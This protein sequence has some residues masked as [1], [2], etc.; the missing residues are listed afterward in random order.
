MASLTGDATGCLRHASRC[1]Q[2][3]NHV[4]RRVAEQ[5]A[6][7]LSEGAGAVV[8]V[9][10]PAGV[11]RQ[12]STTDAGGELEPPVAATAWYHASGAV[13][14]RALPELIGRAAIHED[15]HVAKYT[16]ACLVAA[17]RDRAERSLYLAAAA[18]L[19]A[20]WARRPDAFRDDL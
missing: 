7:P 17:E 13:L 16:L 4:L 20:W 1:E 10:Q 14:E 3:G 9:V 11:Q 19:V 2:L 12:T 18:S 8:R 5:V 15:A 6:R